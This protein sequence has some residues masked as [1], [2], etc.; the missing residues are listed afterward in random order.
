MAMSWRVCVLIATSIVVLSQ[1]SK[2]VPEATSIGTHFMHATYGRLTKL[3]SETKVLHAT[4]TDATTPTDAA[5]TIPVNAEATSSFQLPRIVVVGEESAGKSSTLERVT[6]FPLFPM[7]RYQCTRMPIRV[8]LRYQTARDPMVQMT[9]VSTAHVGGF[10]A[11]V[12][13]VS[14][15]VPRAQV[16]ARVSAVM[17]AVATSFIDKRGISDAELVIT[18]R[19][20][21]V[22]TIDL[23]DLPGL[24]GATNEAESQ[25][26][27]A[28]IDALAIKYVSDP[29]H[30][31]FVLA[32]FRATQLRGGRGLKL[33]QDQGVLD[34]VIGVVTFVN[35]FHP[36][37][38]EYP[39]DPYHEMREL[40]EGDDEVYQ[41]YLPKLGGGYVGVIGRNSRNPKTPTL[42]LLR[43]ERAESAWFAKHIPSLYVTVGIEALIA[44]IDSKFTPLLKAQWVPKQTLALQEL[45]VVLATSIADL[46]PSAS[47]ILSDYPQL[48]NGSHGRVIHPSVVGQD[49]FGSNYARTMAMVTGDPWLSVLGRTPLA[50]VIVADPWT[51]TLDRSATSAR[52]E[53]TVNNALG[54]VASASMTKIHATLPAAKLGRFANL[55]DALID[56][57]LD[58]MTDTSATLARFSQRIAHTLYHEDIELSSLDTL[59]SR[60]ATPDSE[61]TCS[62][63]IG[64]TWNLVRYSGTS[65]LGIL[66]NVPPPMYVWH[67]LRPL[68]GW[69]VSRPLSGATSTNTPLFELSVPAQTQLDTLQALSTRVSDMQKRLV[70]ISA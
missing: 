65:T 26:L 69:C 13:A 23:V 62:L 18:V 44:R 1:S 60:L 34:R 5:S 64:E 43:E 45:A 54:R 51:C 11:A 21:D 68:W 41:E 58:C 63:N 4:I 48:L 66:K 9:R 10:A 36:N 35:Q 19:G 33:L 30:T 52:I 29:T 46:G 3:A 59:R 25:Q 70:D 15:Q 32:V 17:A 49:A 39:T 31:T 7:D 6:G 56:T 42:D 2:P 20:P 61:P 50:D 14:A 22:P 55:E 38:E 12:D 27:S 47:E 53:A 67:A 8:E 57:W 16:A 40:L 24:I 37:V 28:A